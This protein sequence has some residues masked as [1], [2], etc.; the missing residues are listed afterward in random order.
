MRK[1]TSKVNLPVMF[2]AALLVAYG[3]LVVASAVSAMDA[4]PMMVRRHIIGMLVGLVPM[5]L[6][7]IVDY[8]DLRHWTGPLFV[9]NMALLGVVLLPGMSNTVKGQNSWL[10]IAG[11]RLFQPSE[12]AKLLLIITLAAVIS[13]FRGKIDEPRDLGKVLVYLA[14]PL[15]LIML[16]PDLGTALVFV[17]IAGGML[18]VGGMRPKYFVVGALVGVLV[19]AG[20][21][22][23]GMLKEYQL[24]RILVF[25][26]PDVDPLGAGYNLAQSKIAIGSG[27]LTGKGMGR[28][29]QSNLDFLPERHTDFVFSVLGEELGFAGTVTLLGLYLALLVS[30][31]ALATS[32]RDLFGSLLAVGLIAMWTFQILVNVGMTIGIMPIT[33]IPLPFVSFG[34]SFMVT[35]LAG[36]GMLQSVWSRRYGT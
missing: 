9:A 30:A 10:E 15:A 4:G 3:T 26:K 12:P 27:G 22:R 11:H 19:F 34:S 33:G 16:Q 18:L 24:N 14:G 31:L 32:S 21:V 1:L 13:E 2:W 29:T 20:A 35:N 25:V 7:W 6:A 17:A 5:A 8:Q 28:G 36:I 23:F